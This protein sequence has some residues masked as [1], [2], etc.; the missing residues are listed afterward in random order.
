MN[1]RFSVVI[2]VLLLLAAVLASCAGGK[3]AEP[4]ERIDATLSALGVTD[5]QFR[6][7]VSDP[8]G[9]KDGCLLYTSD[10]TKMGYFFDPDSGAPVRILRS[11]LLDSP[12]RED[13]PV[14]PEPM[15]LPR[16]GRDEALIRYAQALLGEDLIGQLSILVGQDEGEVHHYTVY[17]T[18]DGIKTGTRIG[19][20]SRSNG[21]ITII[22][23]EPGSVFKP[24]P[25]G[26]WVIAD[27]DDLIG[28]EAAIK[29][30][31]EGFEQLD[32]QIQGVSDNITCELDATH[33]N[34]VYDVKIPFTE[35]NGW[36]RSYMAVI[37][38]HTGE[39]LQ[40][41]LSK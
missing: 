21:S 35:P 26:T 8:G 41:L 25:F 39:L 1:K 17:E 33:D 24:G 20:S 7:Q 23:V 28:E 32:V 11:D 4:D 36:I 40:N 30:A 38:A 5:A 13:D 6:E 16:E 34:L 15:T 12:Y 3:P 22:K 9:K 29:I 31:R 18:Y 2:S 10:T 19:F 14:A 27:G 37:D